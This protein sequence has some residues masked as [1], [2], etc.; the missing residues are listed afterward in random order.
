M[1]PTFRSSPAPG[2]RSR[3]SPRLV[4]PQ[5]F[6]WNLLPGPRSDAGV[7]RFSQVTPVP[8]PPPQ[9]PP[10]RGMCDILARGQTCGAAWLPWR[11]ILELRVPLVPPLP[12]PGVRRLV[13]V[14]RTG[15][16]AVWPAARTHC[17]VCP[18]RGHRKL[19]PAP[20]RSLSNTPQP[21]LGGL[22]TPPPPQADRPCAVPAFLREGSRVS[23][24]PAKHRHVWAEVALGKPGSFWASG[25]L[26]GFKGHLTVLENSRER[27]N[28]SCRCPDRGSCLFCF[29]QRCLC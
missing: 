27:V 26:A 23:Q 20:A 29:L 21:H 17:A 16:G 14:A 5:I 11:F 19:G 6:S 24:G 25:T 8:P 15:P 10:L 18:S 12:P 1:T 9:S 3:R 7:T 13:G 22:V 28:L 2:A 4:N